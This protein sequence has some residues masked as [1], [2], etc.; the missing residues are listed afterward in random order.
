MKNHL[1]YKGSIQYAIRALRILKPHQFGAHKGCCGMAGRKGVHGSGIGTLFIDKEFGTVD[2]Y[3]H[4]GI[5]RDFGGKPLGE[6]MLR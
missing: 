1:S 2:H 3:S 6:V 5:G 4:E